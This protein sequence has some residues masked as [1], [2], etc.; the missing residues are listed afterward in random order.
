MLRALVFVIASN[1]EK[2]AENAKNNAQKHVNFVGFP[3]KYFTLF[4]NL[5]VKLQSY[6]SS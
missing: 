3:L 2:E 5:R 4:F 1:L 6:I